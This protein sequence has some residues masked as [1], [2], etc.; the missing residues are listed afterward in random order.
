MA[1]RIMVTMK[2]F[3]QI[4][5]KLYLIWIKSYFKIRKVSIWRNHC[6]KFKCNR[7]C[8]EHELSEYI[9]LSINNFQTSTNLLFNVPEIFLV[10]VL[11]LFPTAFRTASLT[12]RVLIVRHALANRVV[13]FKVTFLQNRL[14]TCANVNEPS[15]LPLG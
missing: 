9:K 11:G 6:Q 5:R 4:F 8:E 7:K 12:S 2:F 13:F 15:Y 1:N 10:L 3:H 14:W